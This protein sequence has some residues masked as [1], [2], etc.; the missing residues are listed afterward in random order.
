M[1]E[2]NGTRL[3]Q[4]EL[5]APYPAASFVSDVQ[6][7]THHSLERKELLEEILDT[8]AYLDEHLLTL[9]YTLEQPENSQELLR[10][11][12]G[13][14]SRLYGQFWTLQLH[15]E[16]RMVAQAKALWSYIHH[17][18]IALDREHLRLLSNLGHSLEGHLISFA[19]KDVHSLL[20]SLQPLEVR[21]R[22]RDELWSVA[23]QEQLE[24]AERDAVQRISFDWENSE[25]VQIV[26]G[27]GRVD[28]V[29]SVPPLGMDM[30]SLYTTLREMGH[31][32]Q[33]LKDHL[34]T[35][36][37]SVVRQSFNSIHSLYRYLRKGLRTLYS[38]SDDKIGIHGLIFSHESKCLFVPTSQWLD[39]L[40]CERVVS[41]HRGTR[42][43]IFWSG[44]EQSIPL[45]LL[46]EWNAQLSVNPAQ[47]DLPKVGPQWLRDTLELR[48]NMATSESNS[49]FV[50][51]DSSSAISSVLQGFCVVMKGSQS[52]Y[53]LHV[54]S[55]VG[56]M[57]VALLET[58]HSKQQ[59]SLVRALGI[60]P[61]SRTVRILDTARFERWIRQNP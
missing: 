28:N 6:E 15:R 61:D 11:V 58:A 16:F 60:L 48:V 44:A 38:Q 26:E 51:T 24:G 41:E 18:A 52:L 5:Q 59:E 25:Q 49:L 27:Q 23:V 8:L 22:D 9:E 13:A 56:E 31:Q 2:R 45:Y 40:P 32:L 19:Q 14:L 21:R 43:H 1:N 20:P 35:Q 17:G 3:V 4:E 12:L 30:S 36:V 33:D 34:G 50:E 42:Q 47:E 7:D 57:M 46:A 54:Q 55:I 10:V 53:A 29:T 37:S 39:I